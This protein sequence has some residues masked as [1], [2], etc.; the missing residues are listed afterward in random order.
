MSVN[1]SESEVQPYLTVM[2]VET[3]ERQVAVACINSPRNITLS[4]SEKEINEL[5]TKF[6]RASVVH[7][8]LKVGVA[9]HSIA[10]AEIA[11][12][13]CTMIRDLT[14]GEYMSRRPLMISSVT[15]T[16]IS[17]HDAMKSEYWVDNLISQVRFSDAFLELC[18]KRGISTPTNRQSNK[19]HIAVTDI[20]ELGPHSSLKGP[21]NDV[22]KLTVHD[23]SITYTAMLSRNVSAVTSSLAAMGHMYC[24]GYPLR[25]DAINDTVAGS[26]RC[27]VLADLPAYP[28]DHS[29]SYWSE[30]R[31]NKN[32]RLN[33][34]RPHELLGVPACDWDPMDARWRQRLRVSETHWLADHKV[35]VSI[36]QADPSEDYRSMEL[37]YFPLQD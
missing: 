16:A 19:K 3:S 31:L 22:L 30:S 9:Y 12:E 15:G 20:L 14:C 21:I 34:H 27:Q 2:P 33:I 13:Y 6:N 23:R 18:L 7:R 4:G 36:P 1:L 10:M 32:Y 8:K 5:A 25:L 28:F 35:R 24:Q 26:S 17:I 29:K 11:C 37:S